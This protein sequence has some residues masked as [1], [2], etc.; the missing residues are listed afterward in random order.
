MRI[1]S[2][3]YCP[4]AACPGAAA[5]F[6]PLAKIAKEDQDRAG[7]TQSKKLNNFGYVEGDG[8]EREINHRL[9]KHKEVIEHDMEA[10]NRRLAL[11][12]EA[13]YLAQFP[14][15]NKQRNRQARIKARIFE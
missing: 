10:W 1:L 13:S 5:Y 3:L 11:R 12:N 8:R 14:A 4:P 2:A 7:K 6:E 9:H 15:V